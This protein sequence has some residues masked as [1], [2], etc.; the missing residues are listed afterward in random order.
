MDLKHIEHVRVDFY[1]KDFITN[2]DMLKI[3]S[4]EEEKGDTKPAIQS[5]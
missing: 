4:F 3:M 1:L 2:P 5:C